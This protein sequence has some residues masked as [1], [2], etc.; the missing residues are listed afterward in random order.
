MFMVLSSWPKSLR[1]FSRFIWWMQ[2]ERRVDAKPQTKANWRAENW[3]LLPKST[4]AIVIITQSVSW[5]SCYR[6]TEG[7]RLSR[8]RHCSKGAQPMPKAV[9][10]SSCRDKHNRPQCDSNMGPLTPQ[11]DAQTTRPLRHN[12]NS[13]TKQWQ[14]KQQH[15]IR[16]WTRH[17]SKSIQSLHNKLF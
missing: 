11:S 10:R 9:N 7:G 6:P 8:N 5:Y 16:W 15:Y 3:L 17:F 1:E 14:V 12:E 2:T 4:I 13:L